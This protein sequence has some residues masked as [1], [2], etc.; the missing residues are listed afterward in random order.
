MSHAAPP[1]PSPDKSGPRY[2]S[3]SL[4]GVAA[5]SSSDSDE[6]SCGRTPDAMKPHHQ[7]EL[8]IIAQCRQ[9]PVLSWKVFFSA[10]TL[11]WLRCPDL[12]RKKM[13]VKVFL[14]QQQNLALIWALLL[15]VASSGMF[16]MAGLDFQHAHPS[17][18]IFLQTLM[19]MC[20]FFF[21]SSVIAFVFAV[22]GSLL[23]MM[24]ARSTPTDH[25]F[26]TLYM[27]MG[28]TLA[29]LP[30]LMG[31]YGVLA[32]FLGLIAFFGILFSEH[33]T[34]CCLTVCAI[35]FPMVWYALMS[36]TRAVLSMGEIVGENRRPTV[37]N[38][39]DIYAKLRD[40][41]MECGSLEVVQRAEFLESIGCVDSESALSKL[42]K[43]IFD[44]WISKK[45]QS[46]ILEEPGF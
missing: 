8:D 43:S 7:V 41:W 11:R 27:M 13:T 26:L 25:E 29:S 17:A 40:Y 2:S 39:Q 38:A 44:D 45:I 37:S 18:G 46:M 14:H 21:C 28:E 30:M 20:G 32:A 31:M 1:S 23:L 6:E 3:R 36:L 15:S 19:H 16:G 4:V 5:P 9:L 33:Y 10:M 35:S 12:S 22:F 34:Y 42:A 24:A